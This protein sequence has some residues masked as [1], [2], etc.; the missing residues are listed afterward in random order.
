MDGPS[1]RSSKHKGIPGFLFPELLQFENEEQSN[2]AWERAIPVFTFSK[3]AWGIAAVGIVVWGP[4]SH[5]L[6]ALLASLFPSLPDSLVEYTSLAIFA[7]LAMFG[8]GVALWLVRIPIRRS[9]RESLIACGMPLCMH[10][11]YDVRG[12]TDPRCPECGRDFD[13]KLRDLWESLRASELAPT[14]NQQPP[15]PNPQLTTDH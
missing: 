2:A 7:V 6:E 12:Q 9:L 15:T 5:R 13:P 1:V 3:W 8:A 11:G 10:C 14:P 4:S